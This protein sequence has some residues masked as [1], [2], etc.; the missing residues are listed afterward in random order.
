MGKAAYD[1]TREIQDV[2]LQIGIPANLMGFAYITNAVQLVLAD[3][4][5]LQHIVKGLYVD[6]AGNCAS[7]PIRVER[8][9]RHA[10]HVAWEQGDIEFIEMLFRNSVNPLKGSPTN[11]QFIARMYY[12]FINNKP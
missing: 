10:I 8:A 12:Y 1:N 11:A 6:V 7:T 2:L 5:E 3:P 4:N 9:I